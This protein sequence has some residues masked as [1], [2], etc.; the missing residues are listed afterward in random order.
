[1]DTN[2]NT[3]ETFSKYL[4]LVYEKNFYR[5]L[6]VVKTDLR[7]LVKKDLAAFFNLLKWCI[8]VLSNNNE[9]E[10]A[11][12]LYL[13]TI[14]EYEKNYNKDDQELCLKNFISSFSVLPEISDKGK[15]KHRL[16]KFFESKNISDSSLQHFGVYKSFAVDSIN[17]KDWVEGLR[18]VL[19]SDDYDTLINFT[20]KFS[21]ILS[22]EKEKNFFIA[23]VSLELILLKNLTLSLKYVTNYVDQEN[24]LQKNHPIKN[25]AYLLTS[26]L[27]KDASNFDV[28]WTFI[29][30]YKPLLDL[31]PA[32]LKY[33]NKISIAY[34]NKA[35]IQE[36]NN[37]NIMN[38]LKAF[39]G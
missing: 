12:T 8:S 26:L 35:I 20:D 24:H 25:F 29:N 39:S 10:S 15:I 3:N 21:K 23:R 9:I 7:K 34:F 14:D 33:L 1:M 37:M 16:L 28:F 38:L 30:L 36:E 22:N 18:Y 19:K 27:C 13:S 4:S 17:N 32:F 6:L 2:S 31:D 11:I 5:L